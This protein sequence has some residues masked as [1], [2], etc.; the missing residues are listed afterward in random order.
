MEEKD[1]KSRVWQKE[2]WTIWSLSGSLNRLNF[3]VA[4]EEGENYLNDSEKFAVD[5][6]ELT[7]ISSAGLRLL[8]RLT[9]NATSKKKKFA[10]LSPVGIVKTVLEESRMDLFIPIL[11]SA[12]ELE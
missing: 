7:Y 4:D 12:E 1:L 2:D 10:V 3:S 8:M 11:M 6:S 9:K 5:L